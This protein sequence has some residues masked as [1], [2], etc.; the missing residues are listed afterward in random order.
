MPEPNWASSFGLVTVTPDVPG[1]FA[2][3][4]PLGMFTVSCTT[5]TAHELVASKLQASGANGDA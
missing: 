4:A 1:V 2:G 3:C 5:S